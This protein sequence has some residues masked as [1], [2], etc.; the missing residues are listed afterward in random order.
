MLCDTVTSSSHARNSDQADPP[1]GVTF[2][3]SGE[4]EFEQHQLH[5]RRGAVRLA[6]EFVDRDGDGTEQVDLLDQ[7]LAGT[8]REVAGDLEA[9][10]LRDALEG[11]REG[12][13]G[14]RDGGPRGDRPDRPRRDQEEMA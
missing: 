11:E 9:D 10:L 7:A 12:G 14:G 2:E 6:D 3:P 1:S 8:L 13:G 4:L 5:D